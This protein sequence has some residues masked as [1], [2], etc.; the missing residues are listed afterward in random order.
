M[1]IHVVRSGDTI[2]SIARRY[3]VTDEQII[4][5]NEIL[6][7]SRL[8][9]GQTLVIM[10]PDEVYTVEPGDSLYSIA[11]EHDL[12]IQN[13]LQNNP[14]I[15]GREIMPGEE[16]VIS[17][18]GDKLGN[19][20]V[21]GYAYPY[22]DR[23]VLLR[24]LPYLTYISIFTYGFTPEGE[25][26]DIDDEEIIAM[27]RDYGV[28]PL[29]QV[30][31]Y[32]EAG[33][34]DSDL[35]SG[36]LNN[37]EAQNNLIENIMANLEAKN[38]YG[39]DIDFEY[40]FPE[41]REVFANFVEKITN[42]A[43]EEG[44]EVMIALAPKLSA[45]QPGLLYEA[46]DYERLGQIVDWALIM[47]YEW[48]YT[49]GPPMAVAPYNEVRRVLDYAVTDIEPRKIRMG[50]PN[51]G[52][53]W[54][55]PFVQGESRATVVGNVGAVDLAREQNVAIEFDEVARAPFFTYYDEQRREHIVWFEDARS[56]DAKLRLLDEYELN[57]ASYW[58]IMRYFPQNWFVLISLYNII[59]VI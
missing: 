51:Y 28:A 53:D 10:Y 19:T 23:E 32:S 21:N 42:R 18:E 57:G 22:I 36:L 58:T 31:T 14:S 43:H 11:L 50:V 47:T 48:G 9:V 17:F 20:T 52:Y 27:A 25:L 1:D 30:S 44:Y 59:K 3:G 15:I 41:D 6:D 34:F 55:L 7:P 45:D 46:H 40:I 2:A 39:L 56:I 12:S 16:L 24:T 35:A 49:Y 29:M 33:E 37:E 38:Y 8:V 13:I 4:R 5:D 26:I 54:T